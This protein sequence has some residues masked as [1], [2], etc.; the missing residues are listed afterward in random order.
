M[1]MKSALFLVLCS[2]ADADVTGVNVSSYM[3]CVGCH[4]HH[5]SYIGYDSTSA[6]T[7][8]QFQ[9]AEPRCVPLTGSYV[10]VVMDVGG[11]VIDTS[12]WKAT[13]KVDVNK[14]LTAAGLWQN[15]G[16]AGAS[17]NPGDVLTLSVPGNGWV[18]NITYCGLCE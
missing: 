7:A 9:M 12:S 14:K 18:W 16:Q 5:G 13:F 8:A 17:G 11:V 2:L 3:T 10:G 15:S 1:N 6:G 4:S